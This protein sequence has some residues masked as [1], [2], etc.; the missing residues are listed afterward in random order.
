MGIFPCSLL[1]SLG[2]IPVVQGRWGQTVRR[3][4]QTVVISIH[5]AI[6]G[7]R[8]KMVRH[9]TVLQIS[10][11]SLELSGTL[12]PSLNGHVPSWAQVYF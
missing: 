8:R 3:A 1:A 10:A 4:W 12:H 7:K 9:P 2:D 5:S 11:K 6:S